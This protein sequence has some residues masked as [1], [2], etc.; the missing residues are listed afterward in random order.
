MKVKLEIDTNNPFP[1]AFDF[2]SARHLSGPQPLGFKVFAV[3][4]LIMAIISLVAFFMLTPSAEA[5]E[6]SI[7]SMDR[8]LRRS[9][10]C[11][12]HVEGPV[13][14]RNLFKGASI[15]QY[16]CWHDVDRDGNPDVALI[17]IF[18]INDNMFE[19]V[20]AMRMIEYFHVVEDERALE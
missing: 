1:G 11:N 20:R 16:A 15:P 14:L 17:Y 4:V 18:N 9:V 2:L 3:F 8:E 19:L 5:G 7:T 6:R 10:P 12:G 13:Y